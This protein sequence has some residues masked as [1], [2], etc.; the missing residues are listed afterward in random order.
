VNVPA[1]ALAIASLREALQGPPLLG[2]TRA[3]YPDTALTLGNRE[4]TARTLLAASLSVSDALLDPG[5]IGLGS[6]LQRLRALVDDIS[7]SHPEAHPPR[8][9][10]GGS[11][12]FLDALRLELAR[13]TRASLAV[14][15]LMSSGVRLLEGPLRAALLRGASIRLVTTD[16]L[17]TTEPAALRALIE[18]PGRLD[19]RVYANP[20]RSFHPKVYWFE[21]ADGSGRAYIGS[22]NLSRS[23][24]LDGIE[25]TW[26]VFDFDCGTPMTEIA[27]AFD[28]LFTD[29]HSLP[30]TPDWIERYAQRRRPLPYGLQRETPTALEPRPMQQLALRELE[31]LRADGADKALVIAATGLGKTFLAA[32][33]AST[34]QR[35]LFIAHREE[36]LT[37][38][39]AAY[40]SVYPARSSG[41]VQGP[42]RDID[43]DMVFATIQTLARGEV[44]A[45]VSAGYFDHVVVDE[46][47][48]AAAD[49]YQRVLAQLQPRFL[50]GLTATPYRADNRDV[51]R[52]C[53]D[54]VAYQVGLFEAIALGWLCPFR[55]YGVADVVHYDD[56]LLNAAR[57]G[58]DAARLN[59]R[60]N[61]EQ[62][63]AQVLAEYRARPSHAAL[64]FC[65]SIEHANFMAAFF[66][67]HGVPA[68]SVH[69]GPDSHDRTQAIAQLT[70]GAARVLFTVDLFNEGVDIPCVDQVLF[71]RPT[72][73]MTVFVQQLGRGL[74]LHERKSFLTVVDFIGNYRRASFKLPFLTGIE[75]T[76]PDAQRQAFRKLSAHE[77]EL[78]LDGVEIHL[79]PVAL[80]LLKQSLDQG[81]RLKD[82]LREDWA[83]LVAELGR[84]PLMM[85]V[86]LRSRF[87]VRQFRQSFGDWFGVLEQC[88]GMTDADRRLQ[89][90]C[91]AFVRELETTA[92]TKSYKMVTL[93]AMFRDGEFQRAVNASALC[94]HFRAHFAK[95]Q[96]RHDIDG[97]AIADIHGVSERSLLDYLR[98]NPINALVGG[99]QASPSPWLEWSEPAQSLIYIGP[100]A[101][102]AAA[103]SLAVWQRVEWR[104]HDYLTRP[105]PGSGLYK[106]VPSGDRL[107]VIFGKDA[108]LPRGWQTVKINDEYLYGKFVKIALNV[109][110]T[111]PED[112]DAAPNLITTRLQQLFEGKSVAALRSGHCVR[113]TR[114]PGED[115]L[116]IERGNHALTTRRNS[117]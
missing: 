90:Q 76:D 25:W 72:E 85:E 9:H 31:R 104:L 116:L 75:G 58:Y 61:T 33:D 84:A 100:Q 115:C 108:P 102:D 113:L 65:V 19:L 10:T 79:A 57:T 95:E 78:M 107:C 29:P 110:K 80:S 18:I 93:Q 71:L 59:L 40:R 37:Q 73:S 13:C 22:A 43:R 41:F 91:G 30:L 89:A 112:N 117:P 7:R 52:L 8:L 45:G 69:S 64:G 34:F 81:Q 27:L 49:S 36:L 5:Q 12:S 83:A 3:Q 111:Q 42:A 48:H 97:T 21:H 82:A 98:K 4:L 11:G 26:S 53:D 94:Q 63:A 67:T 51:H 56:T 92:M 55:Y 96:H 6:R 17:D 16:Y 15:F 66:T 62:R 68:L 87:S 99:N 109:I 20:A 39:E 74:R 28:S 44:L 47:H 35:T 70:K 114:L 23:G 2:E 101:E 105:G 24:L 50:L 1:L 106:I 103:F 60:Y 46:F 77:G 38:A 14:A 86:E 88:G 32:F 54:N